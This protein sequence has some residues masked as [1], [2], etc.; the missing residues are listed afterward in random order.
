[1]DDIDREL[2]IAVNAQDHAAYLASARVHWPETLL[3]LRES[4]EM[5]DEANARI[6]RA[7]KLIEA[8]DRL[9]SAGEAFVQ[10]MVRHGVDSPENDVV[11]AA[12]FITLGEYREA[13]E[14]L[15]R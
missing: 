7:A 8:A 4:M 6:L 14:R 12:F 10:S 5:L 3:R 11:S 13:K 9:Q 1:M 2:D 15:L